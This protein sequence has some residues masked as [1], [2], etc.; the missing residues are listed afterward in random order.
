M[1]R[2][3]SLSHSQMKVFPTFAG[4]RSFFLPT[5]IDTPASFFTFLGKN[6]FVLVS[7]VLIKYCFC[8]M[9]TAMEKKSGLQKQETELNLPTPPL[10]L[11]HVFRKI[12]FFI[13]ATQVSFFHLVTLDR[14]LRVIEIA[15]IWLWPSTTNMTCGRD[16]RPSLFEAKLQAKDLLSSKWFNWFRINATILLGRGTFSEKME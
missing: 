7:D 11:R 15:N 8:V 5:M 12:V 16:C 13:S 10:D 2:R 9:M 4:F 3:H 14:F 6:T 1:R